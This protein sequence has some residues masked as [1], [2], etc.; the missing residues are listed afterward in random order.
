MN[1]FRSAAGKSF[2]A[3]IRIG[4]PA[5]QADRLEVLGR[6]VFEIGIERGRGAVRAHVA[7]HDGVAVGR[8][9]RAAGDAGGA[10]GAGDVLDDELLAERLAT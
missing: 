10:A 6:V 9:L 2:L 4:V 3:T 7:H 8:R 1:S 5:D